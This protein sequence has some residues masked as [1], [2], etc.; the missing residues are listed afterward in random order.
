[1]VF[2]TLPAVGFDGP[3][4]RANAWQIQQALAAGAHGC[5]ICEM[6]SPEAGEI[7]I[8]CARSKF[9]R[10]GVPILPIE[11]SRGS[12]SQV[13]AAH[14]WGIPATSI[15]RWPTP[16]RTIPRAKSPWASSWRTAMAW[17]MP[18]S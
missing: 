18:S 5:L 17:K 14:I 1:M 3:S 9:N 4:M 15:W 16:G 6:H 10:P 12:G 11:G 7:A 13:F 8:S 2:V